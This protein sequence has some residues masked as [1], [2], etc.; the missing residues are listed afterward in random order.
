MLLGG[1]EPVQREVST[2][3]GLRDND[4]TVHDR[5]PTFPD[6]MP[7]AVAAGRLAAG[8]TGCVAGRLIAA[9][10]PPCGGMAGSLP[11][12]VVGVRSAWLSRRR[13]RAATSGTATMA[14]RRLRGRQLPVDGLSTAD[15]AAA[16]P[17]ALIVFDGAARPSTPTSAAVTAFGPLRP[18]CRCSGNSARRRCRS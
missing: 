3:F 15:L 11:T 4:P 18:G 12:V 5:W 8:G 13:L 7:I 1:R 16:V 6:G 2:G 14:P 17:D 10:L 9:R